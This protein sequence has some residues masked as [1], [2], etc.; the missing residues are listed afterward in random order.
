LKAVNS[1]Q[2]TEEVRADFGARRVEAPRGVEFGEWVSPSPMG[3]G[4]CPLP[5]KYFDF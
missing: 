1:H 5:R 3:R 4:L 2:I